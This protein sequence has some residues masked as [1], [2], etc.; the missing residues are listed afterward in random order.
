MSEAIRHYTNEFRSRRDVSPHDAEFLFADMIASDDVDSLANLLSAWSSKGATEDELFRFATIMRSR[1]KRLEHN[2]DAVV[3]IVGTGGSRSKTFNVS[4]AAAFVIAGAGIPVAKHGNRAA[5]SSSGSSDV[6]SELGINVDIEP[7][8]TANNLAD[9]GICFMF[10]PRFH[11][12][13]PTLAAARKQVAG[14]TIFNNLGPLCNPSLAQHQVIGV[15]DRS[16]VTKTARVL[17]RLGTTH[18]WVV[19]GSNGL[20]EIALDAPTFVA[21]IKKGSINELMLDAPEI[22]LTASAD[23]IPY[24]CNASQS[25]EIIE[26]ILNNEMNNSNAE[27]LVVLNAATAILVY[28]K[29]D[30]IAQGIGT[31]KESIVS[32][33]AQRKLNELRT[34]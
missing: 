13:S 16:L 8:L 26:A 15:W 11:S 9:H 27:N 7:E 29:A 34:K 3:D 4:T 6:L 32:G 5:T 22:G 23:R 21:E 19:H 14:P 18:S 31:A 17:A 1:M 28:G 30:D 2:Y 33:N 12:L 25:C 20:D 10:A 24:G